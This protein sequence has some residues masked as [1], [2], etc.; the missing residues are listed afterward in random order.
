MTGLH[1]AAYF[2]VYKAA[3]TLIRFGQSLDLKDSNSK[4]PLS[5]A[6]ENGHEA[7][8]KLLLQKGAVLETKDKQHNRTPL[9]WAIGYGH[10][11]VVKV[12]WEEG[13]KLETK[14]NDG[15]TLLLWAAPSKLPV[16]TKAR[17][18]A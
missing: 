10:D 4:T 13:G 8:V 3:N 9:L 2:G 17:S 16:N 12:L 1:L 14:D 15:Q 11:A 18:E 6:I 7:V 5:Y